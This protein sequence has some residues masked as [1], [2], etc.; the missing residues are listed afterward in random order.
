MGTQLRHLLLQE[1]FCAPSVGS[2]ARGGCVRV[3]ASPPLHV[4]LPR[5]STCAYFCRH[6][7]ASVRASRPMYLCNRVRTPA[8]WGVC[9]SLRGSIGDTGYQPPGPAASGC[10]SSPCPIPGCGSAV[11]KAS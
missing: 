2:D 3:S 5:L 4:R 7:H 9:R 8:L 1:V 11:C 10:A 6:Q